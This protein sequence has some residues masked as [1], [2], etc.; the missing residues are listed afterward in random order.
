VTVSQ[1][2]PP[3]VICPPLNISV[4]NCPPLMPNLTVLVGIVTNCPTNCAYTITQT[5]PAGTPLTPGNHVVIVRTCDCQGHCRDCDVIVHAVLSSNCCNLVTLPR[6]FSGATNSPAGLLPGGALD[7]QFKT[8]APLFT[9][10]NP[11]V[12][13]WIHWLWVPNSAL[14][15]CVGPIPTYANSPAGVYLY[16]NRFFLCSTNQA[17]VQGR[18][19]ADDTGAIYLNG[20]LTTAILPASYAFTNWHPVNLTSGFNPGW[21]EL[22]FRVTNGIT[23]VTGLR[24]E[25]YVTNCCN[26]CL[27]IA[28]PSDIVTNTCAGGVA[29]NY[30]FPFASSGCGNLAS[31]A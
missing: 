21:N 28:C 7:P 4:T 17:S 19:T 5:I 22:V 23:S 18:W 11:Y 14:S 13:A 3:Y 10:A 16:T 29:V 25:I 27:T 31:V 20:I 30:N 1:A 8:G 24:T 15:K 6:L 26:N 12:P 9:T 2:P